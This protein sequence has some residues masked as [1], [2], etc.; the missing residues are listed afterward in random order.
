MWDLVGNPETGFLRTRLI[1]NRVLAVGEITTTQN[2]NL[3]DETLCK[4]MISA[5]DGT[6]TVMSPTE[7]SIIIEGLYKQRLCI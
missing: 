6:N 4:L 7:F 1:Q 2:M 5:S 3:Y